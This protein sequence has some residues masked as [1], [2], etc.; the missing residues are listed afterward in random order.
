MMQDEMGLG[1]LDYGA[2]FYDPVLARWHSVDPKAEKYYNLS[3]YAYCAGNPIKFIDPNGKEIWISWAAGSKNYSYQYKGGKLYDEKGKEFKGKNIYLTTVTKQLNQLK[4]DNV[5]VRD[6]I[7]GLETNDFKN[8]ITN[9]DKK[10]HGKANQTRESK[11]LNN[12]FKLGEN[13]VTQYDPFSRQGQKPEELENKGTRDPRVALAHEL[14]HTS[15]IN[16]GTIGYKTYVTKMD[17]GAS[18]TKSEVDARHIE[19]LIRI[20]TGDPIIA[21]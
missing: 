3:P 21:E 15:D 10:A 19:N 18:E 1:W 20:V 6:M 17:N 13:T 14:K 8:T 9:V 5:E 2:R 12:I 11:S 4:K 7:N 16:S